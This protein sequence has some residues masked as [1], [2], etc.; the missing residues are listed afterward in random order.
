MRAEPSPN[1]TVYFV[2]MDRFRALGNHRSLSQRYAGGW[3][4][5]IS[6]IRGVGFSDSGGDQADRIELFNASW[7]GSRTVCREAVT[8]LPSEFF[9]DSPQLSCRDAADR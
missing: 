7:V 8:W 3:R 9:D 1:D 6:Q 2:P 4:L 5:A